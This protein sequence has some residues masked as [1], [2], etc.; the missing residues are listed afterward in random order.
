MTLLGSYGR[1]FLGAFM[2]VVESV[3][4]DLG[5]CNHG[6]MACLMF[7][8]IQD[9]KSGKDVAY[10]TPVTT[11]EAHGASALLITDE[12]ERVVHSLRV[13]ELAEMFIYEPALVRKTKDVREAHKIQTL[14]IVAAKK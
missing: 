10:L 13:A 4:P 8:V 7:V 14:P 5:D 9:A 12:G 11:S 2:P 1:C 6:G 3:A